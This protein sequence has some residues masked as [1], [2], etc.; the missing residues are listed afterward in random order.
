MAPAKSVA[1]R[2]NKRKVRTE[3]SSPS[4]SSG[5]SASPQP[6]ES[7]DRPV[8]AK[9]PHVSSQDEETNAAAP[10]PVPARRTVAPAQAFEDLYLRQATTEFA[11]DLEKL[12]A[13]SDFHGTKGVG[14][15]VM[16]LQQGTACLG[17]EDIVKVGGA[18]GGR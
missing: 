2:K 3:V 7:Q 17:V 15:L 18:G 14:L 10:K 9:L 1:K 5:G 4:E 11:D 16:A 8:F 12:R 13:A 6:L